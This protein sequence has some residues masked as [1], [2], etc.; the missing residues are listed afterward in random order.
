MDFSEI[1]GAILLG[2]LA[3]LI[4]RALYPGRQKMGLLMTM[5]LGL[6]GSFVGFLIFAELLDIG[7][8]D[9]FDLGGIIGAII[10]AMILIFIYQRLVPSRGPAPVRTP[11]QAPLTA[12]ALEA[13]A[14]AAV[15][16]A[17][18]AGSTPAPA[19]GRREGLPAGLTAFLLATPAYASLSEPRAA[20]VRTRRGWRSRRRG[21]LC[22]PGGS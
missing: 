19:A 14:R 2:I 11:R 8:D 22:R 16:G 21:Q 18:R 1:L 7:D 6:A 3:G 13:N 17:A 20:Q 15:S 9:A 12:G 4:A 5:L 10:G